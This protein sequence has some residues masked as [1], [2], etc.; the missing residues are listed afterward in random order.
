MKTGVAI[1][2]TDETIG[3]AEVARLAEERG[4]DAL[5]LPEHTHIP[6]SRL[7][8][9][10]GG[11]DLPRHYW[12]SLDP[13]VALTVAAA[14]TTRLKLGTGVALVIQRDPIVL[15]KEV[16]TLDLLSGGRV[17][18]GVGAG[19]NR[20]EIENHGTPY[21]RRFGI[22]RERVEAIKALWTQETATYEGRYVQF[23]DVTQWPKPV[24]Q[25]HPPV[26]VGGMGRKV[27]DRVLAYG[28]GWFPNWD[29]DIEDRM[30]ELSRRAEEAGRGRI[31]VTFF[32]A[33][34]DR[35]Q[36]ERLQAAG[37]D[38]VLFY[39]PPRPADEVEAAADRIAAL[40]AGL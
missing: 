40:T 15:A 14:A 27:F 9:W 1:F 2:L 5:F 20:D 29:T 35:A 18:F 13:F 32:G 12:R 11:G 36:L 38:R 28:D 26:W 6:R 4:F 19:W 17:E 3:P 37:V 22:L 30:A 31:P 34:E 21:D 25:P 24:Q 33:A 10:P 8:P 23:H 16:A 39:L 7:T